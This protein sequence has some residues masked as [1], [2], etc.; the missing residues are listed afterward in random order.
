MVSITKAEFLR[1]RKSLHQ[2]TPLDDAAKSINKSPDE[3]AAGMKHWRKVMRQRNDAVGVN[4]RGTIFETERPTVPPEI[5]QLQTH[6][7]MLRPKTITAL[8]CGDPLPG[9]SALDRRS[10]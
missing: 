9:E 6:R 8:I 1:I 3:I 4:W 2:G 5:V 10:A 7:V